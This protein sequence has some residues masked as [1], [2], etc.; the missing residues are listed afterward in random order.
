ME[1]KQIAKKSKHSGT[2]GKLMYT[3]DEL[4]Q[5]TKEYFAYCDKQEPK[6]R[7]TQPGLALHLDMTV[8]TINE[9]FKNT[10]GKYSAVSGIIKKAYAR[11]S[12]AFQQEDKAMPLFLLK[13]PCYGGYADRQDN[14]GDGQININL[15]FGK[16]NGKEAESFGK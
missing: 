14:T 12:D 4:E 5:K 13:Q 8:D 7:Y 10:E 2:A 9:W 1:E 6:R 11:M 3:A 16:N 15:S